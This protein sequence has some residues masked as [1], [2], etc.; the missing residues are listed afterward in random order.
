[1]A[2]EV[3]GP[4]FIWPTTSTWTL[5]H[6]K[7]FVDGQIL[8]SIPLVGVSTDHL[9]C[10]DVSVLAGVLCP[11][12]LE[13][14]SPNN[15]LYVYTRVR[16]LFPDNHSDNEVMVVQ[17]QMQMKTDIQPSQAKPSQG[18]LIKRGIEC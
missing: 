4:S 13:C 18:K 6:E 14:S 9:H 15:P 3:G 11:S 7:A 16:V 1:M 2:T 17:M 10:I 8:L 5:N 12:R